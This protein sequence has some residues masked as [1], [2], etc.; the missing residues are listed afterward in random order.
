MTALRMQPDP[1]VSHGKN[2]YLADFKTVMSN[3]QQPY[4]VSSHKGTLYIVLTF[5]K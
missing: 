2:H 4:G 1:F 5:L 3:K